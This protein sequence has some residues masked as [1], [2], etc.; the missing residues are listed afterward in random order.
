MNEQDKKQITNIATRIIAGRVA[1]GE[2]NPDNPEE[3]RAAA[4]DAAE[5]ARAAY[6]AALEFVS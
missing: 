4:K 1:A 6:F 5:V 3:L 2:V